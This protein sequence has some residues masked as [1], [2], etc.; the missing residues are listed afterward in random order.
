MIKKFIFVIVGVAVL[1]S[2]M[3]FTYFKTNES[4]QLAEPSVG[5]L[6]HKQTRV[7]DESS[8]R[9]I[10]G[11]SIIGFSDAYNTLAW[12]GVPYAKA[13]VGDLRWRAPQRMDSWK[14]IYHATEH[15]NPCVQ[16]WGSL[17]GAEGQKGDVVGSEDCLY[18]NVWAPKTVKPGDE[19]HKKRPVMVWIHGG[20]NDSGTA[21]TYQ[22]HHLAGTQ[23][24]VVVLLNYRLGIM[25]WFSHPS[26]REQAN[27]LEDASGNFGT[28]DIIAGLKWVQENI[29][30]FGGDPNNV[31]I[32]GES[33]GA[34]NVFSMLVS[35]LASGLFHKA[36]A[37]SGSADTT[38]LTLAED[39]P[40]TK[41]GKPISGLKNSSNALLSLVLVQQHPGES[42]TELRSRI[43]S[44][45]A[46]DLLETMRAESAS[47]LMK[48]AA[49][50]LGETD[51]IRVARIVRDGHVIPKASILQRLSQPETYN[52]VPLIVGTNRDEN[53][54]FMMRDDELVE[55]LLGIFPRIK[56][57]AK[58]QRISDYVSRNWKAGAVDEPAKR[59]AKHG[60][61]AVYAYRFDWDD[62]PDNWLADMP[63]LIGAAHGLE[64]SFVF[65]DF[66][67]GAPL[68]LLLN[69]ANALGREQLSTAMMGYWAA[70]AHTG[71]P[72]RG[73]SG[74]LPVWQ[75]WQDEGNNLMIFDSPEDQGI[76][77]A[78][79][80]D[81]VVDIKTQIAADQEFATPSERCEAYATLFLHGYQASDYWDP[82][83]YRQL[84]CEDYPAS[85]YRKG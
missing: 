53:K 58:Y 63:S 8:L 35:P 14:E 46:A 34:K 80:R 26:I 55:N 38:L 75:Q 79:I 43:E 25:G 3:A 84:H 32:F 20:G 72:G 74:T 7:V 22:A 68:G 54:L 6:Y 56:D 76:A 15:G 4:P 65:G 59:I 44:S 47:S 19:G 81:N 11:G 70:F 31:T 71:S 33:A 30:Q 5:G 51:E 13:P 29:E 21:N 61:S 62:S 45:S 2:V 9:S 78:E 83:E 50:N 48:L 36:I 52:A 24:V 57:K 82:V 64:I 16:Y 69:K 49:D 66:I 39:F 85:L 41:G 67:G 27:N 18:L 28:L 40:E 73:R 23:D 12:I 60:A 77:M 1:T 10:S 42:L 37:Q 17:A